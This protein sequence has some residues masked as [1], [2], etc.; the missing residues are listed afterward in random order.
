MRARDLMTSTPVTLPPDMPLPA[1]ARLFAE[2]GISG[3]PVVDTGGMLL[4]MV[5]ESDLIRRIAAPED[6]P[7]SWIVRF[8]QPAGA[9]AAEYARTHGRT[10]QDVMTRG[11]LAVEEDAPI[12]Q[13]AASLEERN[14]RRVPVLREGRLVGIVSR[15]DLIRALLS[16][17]EK[18]REDAPDE[19]IRR[20][21]LAAMREQPWLD[22][23]Y[24][25]PDVEDGVVSFHGWCRQ[26]EVKR[27]LRVLAERIPGVKGVRVMV[28]RNPLPVVGT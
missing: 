27:A 17:A 8:F 12:E 1:I 22:A 15:A 2:R 6:Q 23:F 11:V 21:V 20:D 9:Q 24:V 19:R 25:F 28:E 13:V 10:A 16:P 4:G 18:L 26:E 14:I 7:R 5:T 3:A